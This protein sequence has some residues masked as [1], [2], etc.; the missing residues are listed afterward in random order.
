MTVKDVGRRTKSGCTSC[1]AN[2]CGDGRQGSVATNIVAVIT[3]M[4]NEIVSYATASN[5]IHSR[6]NR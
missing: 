2:G 3:K 5:P 6:Q 4:L 1:D